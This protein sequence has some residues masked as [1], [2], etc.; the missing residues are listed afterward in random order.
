[1]SGHP[2][3]TNHDLAQAVVDHQA[4]L[5]SDRCLE[6]GWDEARDLMPD[7]LASA[8]LAWFQGTSRFDT[9]FEDWKNSVTPPGQDDQHG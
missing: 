5:W 9:V 7:H 2:D 1:M 3:T 6:E 4:F 8:V